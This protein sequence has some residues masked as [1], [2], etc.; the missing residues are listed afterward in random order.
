ML[1]EPLASASVGREDGFRWRGHEVSR[2]EGFSDAVFGFALTLIVVSLEVPQT[3]GQLVHV[4]QGFV[5]FLICFAL[6]V[7]IWLRHY[8]FFRRYGLE[9]PRTRFL[10]S[11]LLFVVLA[12]VYPLKFLFSRVL[13]VGLWGDVA[14]IVVDGKSVP[15]MTN[16]D[17][18]YLFLVYGLGVVFVHGV[19]VLLYLHAWSRREALELEP[20]EKMET[21]ASIVECAIIIGG[22]L[23]S[24]TFA[25]SGFPGLAGW[26]YVLYAPMFMVYGWKV[27]TLRERM[28]AATAPA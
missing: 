8:Q 25:M 7:Q 19:F 16:A 26:S 11:A 6:F 1:R 17:V 4:L 12:Y 14:S 2:L 3:F 28:L 27:R 21:K 23:V 10:N 15:V 13:G 22:A 18:P 24:I 20:V 9:D 5:G